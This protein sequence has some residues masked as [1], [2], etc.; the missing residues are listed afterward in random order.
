M[1]CG[2]KPL[3]KIFT[4][5]K[6]GSAAAAPVDTTSNVAKKSIDKC[7][8]WRHDNCWKPSRGFVLV[9]VQSRIVYQIRLQTRRWQR[10][11]LYIFLKEGYINF[12]AYTFPPL[13]LTSILLE[14]T[15]RHT[16]LIS[17]L[18]R[19][20]SC[21]GCLSTYWRVEIKKPK[22]YE[23]RPNNLKVV[24]DII[25]LNF[26]A[27]CQMYHFLFLFFEFVCIYFENINVKNSLHKKFGPLLSLKKEEGHS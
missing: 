1:K 9:S 24:T 11:L 8:I 13:D 2:P 3:S 14:G 23:K 22:K 6:S 26:E 27:A 7:N 21:C 12:S 18:Y 25:W 19:A 5:N 20:E 10:R 4:Q 17:K 15:F 16:S